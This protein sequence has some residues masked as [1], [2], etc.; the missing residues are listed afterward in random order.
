[1]TLRFIAS[2]SLFLEEHSREAYRQRIGWNCWM[3]AASPPFPSRRSITH[4][5]AA[6]A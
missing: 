1:M 4:F 2:L 3:R 6:P 5:L